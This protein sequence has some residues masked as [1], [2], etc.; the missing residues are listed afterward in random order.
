MTRTRRE[1]VLFAL[2]QLI[3]D[4]FPWVERDDPEW[5]ADFPCGVEPLFSVIGETLILCVDQIVAAGVR[6]DDYEFGSLIDALVSW[7]FAT[8]IALWEGQST[9]TVL[10][11]F[12]SAHPVDCM[13]LTHTANL[14]GLSLVRFLGLDRR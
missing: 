1:E 2:P 3:P 10:A 9:E 7:V 8:S 5:R 14:N 12:E 13:L 4:N 6:L 11:L